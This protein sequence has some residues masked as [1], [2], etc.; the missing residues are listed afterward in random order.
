[1]RQVLI[2]K[3]L[4][5]GE[6]QMIRADVL[7]EKDGVLRVMIPGNRHP[8]EVQASEVTDPAKVFGQVNQKVAS[9]LPRCYPTSL[10]ALGNR[11]R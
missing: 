1:M 6:S 4:L 3:K 9:V 7:S 8:Q 5:S 10:Q 2:R 11:F